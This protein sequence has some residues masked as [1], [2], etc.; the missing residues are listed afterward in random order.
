M[1]KRSG[2]GGSGG[3]GGGSSLAEI[4]MAD[5]RRELQ[6]RQ[7]GA[8]Q[9]V[10]RREKL[11]AKL[12]TLDEQIRMAG[13]EIRAMSGDL[14][15]RKRPKNETNL[16]EALAK[17]LDGKTMS[18]TEVTQ[19]VQDAGYQTSSSSFRT[20]VNQT[21][22]NSGKFKRVGRGLYTAKG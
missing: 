20:I 7:R 6:R 8:G 16:V 14:G 2:K 3:G 18:V 21:L 19:A 12:K 5:L 9:L 22:I 17:V 15:T 1:A 4:S 11:L 10:R 13:G